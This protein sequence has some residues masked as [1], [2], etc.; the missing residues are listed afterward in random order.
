MNTVDVEVIAANMLLDQV[1]K[2]DDVPRVV[3]DWALWILGDLR[4]DV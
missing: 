1:K 3:I 4:E 2:G